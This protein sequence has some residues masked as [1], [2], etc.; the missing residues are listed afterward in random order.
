MFLIF[1]NSCNLIFCYVASYF[2]QMKSCENVSKFM[3]VARHHIQAT[4]S[5][6]HANLEKKW[7]SRC[8]SEWEMVYTL[9]L[10][11]APGAAQKGKK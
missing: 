11:D 1:C 6:G 4:G 8:K 3:V 10:R 7:P 9:L 5:K 2:R